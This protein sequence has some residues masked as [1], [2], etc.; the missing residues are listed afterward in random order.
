MLISQLRANPMVANVDALSAPTSNMGSASVNVTAD[1]S[2][3][4]I[5]ASA[6]AMLAPTPDWIVAFNN[7]RLC[8]RGKWL[9]KRIGPL[10]AYDAGT[11]A[12]MGVDQM[13][14]QNIYR[15]MMGRYRFKSA[16]YY[17]IVRV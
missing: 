9:N 13:P 2:K 4:A 6:I 3:G 12:T 5:H 7:V 17:S 16:G 8:H 14:R 1:A 10:F 11:E 15:I